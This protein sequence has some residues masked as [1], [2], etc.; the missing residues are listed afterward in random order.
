[1]KTNISRRD[2][3][4]RSNLLF[5]ALLAPSAVAT[6]ASTNSTA[7]ADDAVGADGFVSMNN[8]NAYVHQLSEFTKTFQ[9]MSK[10]K[11]VAMREAA[12]LRQQYMLAFKPALPADL[13]VGRMLN[14][15]MGFSAQGCGGFGYG[16]NTSAVASLKQNK[17]LTPKSLARLTELE[18]FWRENSSTAKTRARYTPAMKEAFGDERWLTDPQIGTPLYRIGGTQS[19][20]D[21][22]I[23]LGVDGL[24]E[25]IRSR[26]AKVKK[27]SQEAYT[28]AAMLEAIE[29]FS[30]IAINYANQ[31]T[32]DA[33]KYDD[34]EAMVE[35]LNNIAHKKPTTFREGMQLFYLWAVISGTLNYGRM[36][37]YLGDL[38]VN[39]IDNGVITKE[40]AIAYIGSIWVLMESR[41]KVWDQRVIIGGRGR[42]NTA[43]ADRL[44]MTIMEATE[45]VRS[46]V[47]QLTLRFYKGQDPA[48]YKK[49]LDVIATGNPYPMLYNDEV[50]IPSVMDAF[51][52]PEE[53]AKHYVPYG[54]GEY[55]INHRS[56]GTPSGVI[57]L[58]QALTVV[59]NH[60]I[61]PISGKPVPSVTLP[62]YDSFDQLLDCYKKTVEIYV[63][64]LAV[65]EKLEYDV[66]GEDA[67]FLYL[68]M[69]YDDCL[70][71][72]KGL[73]SGVRYLGGTLETY[74]N[75][76]TA[77]SLLAIKKLVY[78]DKTMSYE[79]MMAALKANFEGYE[80]ERKAMLDAPKYGNDIKEADEM[81]LM[82]NDHVC[83]YTRDMAPKVGL[84]SYLVVIINND[85]NV[86]MGRCT[87][88]S[89][90][91]RFAKTFMANGNAATGG[92]DKNGATSYLNS[93]SK[94]N[95]HIFAGA[96][97]NFKLSREMLTTYRPT[98]EA[99]LNVYWQRGGAQIM[100]N[101]LNRNDLEQAMKFPEQYTNLI[102]R[103]GGFSARFVELHRDVQLEILS[104]TLY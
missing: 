77:D 104:R 70:A 86:T 41:N 98:T 65:Q 44:A 63:H 89:P 17:A 8:P 7:L 52:L 78:D 100:I 18:S 13:F 57:N 10:H 69:L 74:G 22:L 34:P 87:A 80:I 72:G 2:F 75:T 83:N 12:C 102:V 90:D 6:A 76:N 3:V 67:D 43:N 14:P 95:T 56:L 91:G 23:T 50:N 61:N 33:A 101:C 26:M 58:L 97:Q 20:Y 59:L 16:M 47:P 49:A 93:I 19:D 66:A 29:L 73:I 25:T 38:Y 24:T 21:K 96:V 85:A 27:G 103:V 35:V 9:Q 81:L 71:S 92:A 53:V 4:K 51:N 79:T 64:D 30:G 40:D 88:A 62:K 15:V 84:H 82:V 46:V 5:A 42:R 1:M 36:D 68:S 99:M 28:Y 48:L 32:R 60:G 37:E 31:I 94:V 55:I 54:C 45:R 39:D 11:S